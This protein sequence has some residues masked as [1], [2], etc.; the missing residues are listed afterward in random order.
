M[1][2]CDDREGKWRLLRHPSPWAPFGN[3]ERVCM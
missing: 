1:S 3:L 2:F